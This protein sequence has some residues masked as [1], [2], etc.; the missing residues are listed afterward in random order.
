ML[1][2]RLLDLHTGQHL[3]QHRR[4]VVPYRHH[5]TFA[6]NV[7]RKRP[8]THL[9]DLLPQN[10]QRYIENTRIMDNG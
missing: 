8:R 1:A 3:A 2:H 4:I 7:K 6:N 9:H 5:M 10:R